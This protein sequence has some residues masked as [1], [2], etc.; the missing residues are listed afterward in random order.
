MFEVPMKYVII[1]PDGA[2]D[3]PLPQLGGK[4]PLEAAYIPHMDSVARRGC[5]GRVVTIPE[6]FPAGTD[7]G[8]LTLMGY[9]PHRYHTGRAPME[10]LAQQLTATP[11]QLIFRC[12]FVNITDGK[13]KDFTAGHIAQADAEALI[14]ALNETLFPGETCAFH[15]GVSYRNLLLLSDASNMKLESQPPHDI[16]DQ[17]VA[18]YW[19]QGEGAGR[20]KAIMD[21]AADVLANHP[22]NRRRREQGEAWATHIWLWGQGTRM[23]LETLASRYGLTGATITAV[24]IIRGIA[25]GMGMDLI[26]VPG[27]TGYI[28]TDYEGKGRA[29]VDALDRYDVVMVHIEAPDET[30]HQGLAEEKMKSLER[31]DEAIVGPL[32]EKLRSLGH[33]RILIAPDHATLVRTKG[34]HAAPPPFCYAGTG[35]AAGAAQGFTEREAEATG[36]LLDPG[37]G[38]FERFLKG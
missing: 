10:A 21:R 22:V 24:D 8:T 4:T 33:H 16:T 6:G 18:A 15:T 25:L 28:D 36:L 5:L 26:R 7:A 32:L 37:H 27:A 1:L 2:S 30:A 9:D 34:H 19:P 31:I 3:E 17:A 35:V 20:V 14:A 38:L 29:A 13:M 11:D 12:N 23:R